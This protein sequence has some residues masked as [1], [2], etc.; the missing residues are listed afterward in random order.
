MK[1]KIGDK[2]K[3]RKDLVVGDKYEGLIYHDTMAQEVEVKGDIVTIIDAGIDSNDIRWYNFEGFVFNYSEE[4]I[5]GLIENE[6]L[7]KFESFLREVADQNAP[8]YGRQWNY[9]DDLMHSYGDAKSN[10]AELVKFYRTFKPKVVKKLTMA[11]LRDIVG[12]DF[13]IVD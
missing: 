6:E 8:N 9:L 2:V 10:I 11:E 5:E 13:E 4:M 1:Y 7:N 12:E 3:I